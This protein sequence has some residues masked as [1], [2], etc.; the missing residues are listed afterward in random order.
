M[1]GV[2]EHGPLPTTGSTVLLLH[3]VFGSPALL[4]P[5]AAY[6][7]RSGFTCHVPVLRGCDPSSDDVLLE[8]RIDDLV[9]AATEAYD[10]LTTPP[11]LIGHSMGGLVA[12]RVA[13]RRDPKALV[14]LASVP[15]GVLWP[16]VRMLPYLFPVLP[17]VL[18]G[19]P[20]LPSATTMRN[21]PLYNLPPEEQDEVIPQLVRD[22]GRV[23]REMSLGTRATRV[24]AQR[25]ECP[26]LVVS[27]GADRNVASWMSQRLARR[28]RAEHQVHPD[29]PHWIIAESALPRVGPPVVRWIRDLPQM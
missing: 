28:Y 19:R 16:Q 27:G 26:V 7:R 21:V 1:N 22:S 17:S 29:L 24:P 10:A 4:G 15:P 2:I 23:F 5:W 13:A 12:Q 8:T 18:R 20:F 6:L 9:S 11:I 25:V 3:G 14:L